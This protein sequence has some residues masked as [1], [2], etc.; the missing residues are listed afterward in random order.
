MVDHER[1][2]ADRDH[3]ALQVAGTP[4]LKAGSDELSIRIE[5]MER[6]MAARITYCHSL[7]TDLQNVTAE[8]NRMN[9]QYDAALRKAAH[10][11]RCNEQQARLIE[12]LWARLKAARTALGSAHGEPDTVVTL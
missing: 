1:L 5:G 10:Y 12:V 8:R 9:Q 2:Q 3:L 7:A 4:A 6:D 11:E